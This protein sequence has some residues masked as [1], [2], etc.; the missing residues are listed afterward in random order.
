[1]QISLITSFGAAQ[2]IYTDYNNT[3]AFRKRRLTSSEEIL[4]SIVKKLDDISG[5][6]DGVQKSFPLTVENE[7]VIIKDDQLMITINGIIQSPRVYGIVGNIVFAE[8]PKPPSKV[9]Y[10]NIRLPRDL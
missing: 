7:G 5:Q 2:P 9:V 3:G 8:A 6:F 4:T 1:M 10:R